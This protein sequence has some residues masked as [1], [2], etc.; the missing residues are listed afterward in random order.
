MEGAEPAA[1]EEDEDKGEDV[2]VSSMRVR[3]MARVRRL[4][5]SEMTLDG[6]GRHEGGGEG[7]GG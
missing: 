7:A 2:R 5:S 6:G 3:W 1:E 4:F